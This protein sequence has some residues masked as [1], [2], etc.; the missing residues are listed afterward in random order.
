MTFA[1]QF[2][3]E[4]RIVG[5]FRG[6]NV[7]S[8]CTP[9]PFRVNIC[10]VA[11]YSLCFIKC[12]IRVRKRCQGKVLLANRSVLLTRNNGVDGIC[13]QRYPDQSVHGINEATFGDSVCVCGVD[14]FTIIVENPK[15]YITSSMG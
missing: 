13:R 3:R 14:L 1:R 9:P 8:S 12:D 5:E 15:T 4:L 10:I 2:Q 6:M 7:S 11:I